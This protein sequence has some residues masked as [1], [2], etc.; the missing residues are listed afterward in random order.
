[1]G[2]AKSKA[3]L[4]GTFGTSGRAFLISL[5]AREEGGL[6]SDNDFRLVILGSATGMPLFTVS[7]GLDGE[8]FCGRGFDLIDLA[9]NRLIRV[10]PELT[11]I[12]HART[13]Y[14]QSGPPASPDPDILGDNHPRT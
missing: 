7:V 14:S 13:S 12:S 9:R 1:M 4:R 2:A 6:I 3:S 8:R 5:V 10:K 11:S